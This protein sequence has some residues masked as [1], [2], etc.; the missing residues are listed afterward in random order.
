[1]SSATYLLSG[2]VLPYR[3][4]DERGED[5]GMDEEEEG[6]GDDDN[7]EDVPQMKITLANE[8]D[9]EGA[10]VRRSQNYPMLSFTLSSCQISVLVLEFD[11]CLQLGTISHPSACRRS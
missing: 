8:R 10:C 2:T 9:L 1:M 7:G 4:Q 5:K 11:S 6:D 3:S